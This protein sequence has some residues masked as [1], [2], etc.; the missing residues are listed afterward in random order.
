M[1]RKKTSK[2]SKRGPRGSWKGNLRFGLV[3]FPVQAFNVRL[4]EGS[5]IVFHQL[6]AK[7]H[8]R[9]RYE[10][11][12]P[13]HGAVGNDEIVSGYEYAKDRYVEL[14][15]EELDKLR[16]DRDRSL[17]IDTF[18]EPGEL[19]PIYLDGREYYLAADGAAAR[20]PYAVFLEA[21]RQQGRYGVGQVVFSN[22]E[23]VV[24][25][26]PH[27]NVLLMQ[28]LIYAAEI[29]A[30]DDLIPEAAPAKNASREVKMAEELISQW[31]QKNFRISQYVDPF[32]EKVKKLVE[33]KIKGRDVAS[34]EAEEEPQVINL[35]DALRKSMPHGKKVKAPGH[36]KHASRR[37]PRSRRKSA[38]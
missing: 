36:A 17:V 19:D 28:I 25:I 31:T 37:P 38:G 35:M 7:C 3:S 9:I 22:R 33:A 29:R 10:K 18:I 21:L 20:E 26:R 5:D 11:H 14:E 32:H 8:R 2:R 4:P 13:V 23:H 24:V 34:P 15:P 12:C 6:H 16:S 1:A 30:A 27:E